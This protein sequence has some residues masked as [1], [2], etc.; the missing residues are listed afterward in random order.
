MAF[1]DDSEAA[2]ARADA[3]ERENQNLREQ[4]AEAKAAAEVTD[5]APARPKPA[6]WLI[7]GLA[8]TIGG[9]LL[10][11][12]LHLPLFLIPLSVMLGFFLLA[13]G[14]MVTLLIVVPPDELLVLSGQ[15]HRRHDGTEVGYRLVRGGRVVRIPFLERPDRLSLRM[16]T[17][18]VSAENTYTSDSVRTNINAV[19]SVKVASDE[20][21]VHNAVERFL[22]RSR[23]E[24]ETVARETLEGHLRSIAAVLTLEELQAEQIAFAQKLSAE[25]DSDFDK[26]GLMLDTFALETIERS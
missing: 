17:I 22:G 12:Q 19:A 16:M 21:F 20:P 13:I 6:P 23:P 9:P 11:L 10:C 2:W 7:A 8:M 18:H 24:I 3:L 4:L 15:R 1:R 5:A 25:A 14:T 26:L